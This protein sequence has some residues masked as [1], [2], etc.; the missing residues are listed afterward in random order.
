MTNVIKLLLDAWP[1]SVLC[2]TSKGSDVFDCVDMA[3][4]H[5]ATKDL[6]L[7]IL[8]EAREQVQDEISDKEFSE[9]V[10]GNTGVIIDLL[11][12]QNG[13]DEL[14]QNNAQTISDDLLIDLGS[15]STEEVILVD[16]NAVPT[17]DDLDSGTTTLD[18]GV[19]HGGDTIPEEDGYEVTEELSAESDKDSACSASENEASGLHSVVETDDELEAEQHDET[20]R[21]EDESN[22]SAPNFS[23]S[24][25]IE[26]DGE[27]A[28]GTNRTERLNWYV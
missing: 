26:T 27:S 7:A 16:F 1:K 12:F 25:D 24:G 3:G 8:R 28:E 6:V 9:R 10:K 17:Q 21:Q 23:D 22:A 19:E 15:G 2:K 11:D 20:G 5:H 18:A 4:R 14:P 13:D